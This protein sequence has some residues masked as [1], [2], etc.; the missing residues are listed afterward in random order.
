MTERSGGAG[1]SRSWL[2]EPLLHFLVLGVGLFV[3]FRLASGPGTPGQDEIVVTTGQ[4]DTI[5]EV[6]SKL[7]QRPPSL[8][9]LEGLI[10]EHILE[11]VLYRE[12]LAMGLDTDD[13]IIR[14]R[15]RQKLEFL[16]DDFVAAEPDDED[17][18][19][20]M[21]D[22]PEQFLEESTISFTH[23]FFREDANEAALEFLAELRSGTEID[24]PAA[25]DPLPLPAAFDGMRTGEIGALFGTQ[26]RQELWDLEIDAWTGPIVSPYGVH[27]VNVS[28]RS[29]GRLPDLGEIREIVVRE[30]LAARRRAAQKAFFDQLRSQYVISV[31]LPQ[32]VSG[33][34]TELATVESSR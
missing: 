27:L 9:E 28:E 22:S 10:E 8:A 25:G 29:E 7:R 32:W 23:V 11:E 2:R 21:E 33:S 24:L 34:A 30:W 17:L 20:L 18:L 26:F 19:A 15:L 13:T 12:A 5:V 14:R 3:L 31:A 4:I 16:V 6:F 1:L